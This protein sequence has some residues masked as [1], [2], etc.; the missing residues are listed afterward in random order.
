MVGGVA[1]AA[2]ELDGLE[3][4]GDGADLVDLDEDGV[5]DLLFDSLLEAGGVGDEEVV[6]DE[7]NLVAD[8]LGE[9]AASRPS[10]L[11]RGRL[12]WRR[13]DSAGPSRPSRRP[14]RPR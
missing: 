3:G 1:E 2:G 7:L 10:R 12:R 5:G 13:W 11:R 14:F 6:A 9:F 4:F 8:E